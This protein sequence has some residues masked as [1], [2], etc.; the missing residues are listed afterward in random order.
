VTQ[1]TL[2]LDAQ[3]ELGEGPIWDPDRQRLVFVD[4][5]R[6][7]VHAFDPASGDDRIVEVG[8][9]VGAV[10]LTAR[11]DWVM[12][13]GRGF[14]R[15]DPDSGVVTPI[16]EA[17][18]G[19]DDVRMNDGYVDFRG[20][21]WAGTLSLA[22]KPGQGALYRLDP[23]GTVHTMI[24]P[25]TTSNGI[26]WSPDGRLMYYVD[27]RTRRVDV[28]DVAEPGGRVSGRRP[29][30]DVPDDAG[31]PDGLVVDAAGGVWVAL[32]RGRA[33]RR[34]HADGRL[35]RRITLPVSLVTKC[36]FGGPSLEDLFITT[37]WTDLSPDERRAEPLAGGVF[38]V[39]PGVAGQPPRRFGG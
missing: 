10:A 5:M 36:A 38:R 2:V 39:S 20:R 11:G 29:F 23:D 27:T 37:A 19:R 6:G 32:W 26:D 4:I 30:V 7:R 33:V 17:A 3:A 25:V 24:A 9:P 1:P 31:R 14:A 13:T 28:F 18:P 8:Q 21:F 22:R 12:A 34:Y 16:A 15:L 35:D